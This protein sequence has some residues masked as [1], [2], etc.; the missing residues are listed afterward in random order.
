MQGLHAVS[1]LAAGE[2]IWTLAVQA[3]ITIGALAA[4]MLPVVYADRRARARREA[5]MDRRYERHDHAAVERDQ[6]LDAL[7]EVTNSVHDEEQI[8]DGDGDG[9]PKVTLG[10]LLRDLDRKVDVGFAQS[11][12]QLAALGR[13]LSA[14]QEAIGLQSELLHEHGQR[15]DAQRNDLE[16]LKRDGY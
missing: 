15:L 1:V 5:E 3:V 4:V 16:R 7:L 10:T 14:T 11:A 13:E 9:G 12:E 8:P 2:N 6:K